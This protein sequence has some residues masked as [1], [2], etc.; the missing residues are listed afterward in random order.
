MPVPPGL[1]LAGGLATRLGGGDKALRGLAGRPLAAHVAGRLRP[2]CGA[3]WL[4]ANG[5]PARFAAL[6]MAVLPDPVPGRPGPLA[7]V[8][9]GLEQ[10]AAL[11]LEAVV[12]APTDTPFLPQ[13]LVARLTAA[14]RG[15]FAIAAC[16]AEGAERLHPTCGLWPVRLRGAVRA[17]LAAGQRRVGG[18]AR[19]HGAAITRFDDHWAFFNINTP[20]DLAQAEAA[21]ARGA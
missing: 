1:I 4:S 7:G 5:D 2:Q 13:D 3:L 12:T 16:T 15:G 9:A 11:G 8:L 10:A 21:L 20:A 6:G 17:A 18:F 19:D 14:D